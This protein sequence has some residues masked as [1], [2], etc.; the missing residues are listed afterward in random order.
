M[1]LPHLWARAVGTSWTV[2]Q[3]SQC[4]RSWKV[5]AVCLGRLGQG[6]RGGWLGLG[7]N[8]YSACRE[9]RAGEHGAGLRHAAHVHR[10]CHEPRAAQ[11][12][13]RG[14]HSPQALQRREHPLPRSQIHVARAL[15]TSATARS[16]SRVTVTAW[17][18]S[19]A[20]LP[21]RCC[22]PPLRIPSPCLATGS[23]ARLHG[24]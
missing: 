7:V 8:T 18:S 4:L 9:R 17:G 1:E 15:A 22:K 6:R 24:C 16:C 3:G 10:H 2:S 12:W 5:R 14:R 19:S 21:L 11:W 23:S 20:P 13:W